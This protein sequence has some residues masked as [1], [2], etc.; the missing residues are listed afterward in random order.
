MT[1]SIHADTS[2]TYHSCKIDGRKRYYII[3]LQY[4]VELQLNH[5]VWA[6]NTSKGRGLIL[7]FTVMKI[8]KR[9]GLRISI[10][11]SIYTASTGGSSVGFGIAY[12]ETYEY[13]DLLCHPAR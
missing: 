12:A 1:K 11:N 13:P 8:C 4:G 10:V 7:P 2:G 9:R 3:A 6:K 5:G